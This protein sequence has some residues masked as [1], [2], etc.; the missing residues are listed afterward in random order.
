[1]GEA[2]LSNKIVADLCI[3]QGDCNSR[4]LATEATIRTPRAAINSP[5][6]MMGSSRFL[7]RHLRSMHFVR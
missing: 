3:Y 7:C 2:G 5:I 1:M 6:K 4:F